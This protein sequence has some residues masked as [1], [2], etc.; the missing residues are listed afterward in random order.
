MA[1][2]PPAAVMGGVHAEPV[3]PGGDPRLT[4]KAA[5]LGGQ[6]GADILGQILCLGLRPGEAKAQAEEPVILPFQQRRK[7][8]RITASG[9][10]GKGI[11][12]GLHQHHMSMTQA[13][14]QSL[15]AGGIFLKDRP[16]TLRDSLCLQVSAEQSRDL[17]VIGAD[18]STTNGRARD[19]GEIVFCPPGRV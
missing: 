3:E 2:G 18:C 19:Y 5:Q 9:G 11:I 6:G 16:R 4:A 10:Q 13:N 8:R 1:G 15:G 7:S 17:P 14:R 12:I